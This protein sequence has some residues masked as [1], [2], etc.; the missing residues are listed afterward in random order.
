MAACLQ[1]DGIPI[2]ESKLLRFAPDSRGVTFKVEGAAPERFEQPVERKPEW[3]DSYHPN[4]IK[5]RSTEVFAMKR[6]EDVVAIQRYFIDRGQYRNALYVVMSVNMGLR[7]L[8][9]VNLR[10]CDI[11]DNSGAL[12]PEDEAYIFEHKTGKK[13]HLI[14]NQDVVDALRMYIDKTHIVP[15]LSNSEHPHYW[16]FPKQNGVRT[17]RGKDTE[18]HISRMSIG[19]ILKKAA[20]DVG[21]RYNVNTHTLRKTFGY[22]LYKNGTPIEA[23]QRIFNHSST[24]MTERYIGLTL[25][26]QVG[27]IEDLESILVRM[28]E[29]EEE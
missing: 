4:F 12:K 10:W 8:D 22:R 18:M 17:Y 25:D 9:M 14:L 5:G 16:I 3:K 29:N 26:E 24:L 28:D 20:R 1:R 2:K 11:L 19:R 27:Y 21:I 23:I 15:Q 6:A 7:G 13:R